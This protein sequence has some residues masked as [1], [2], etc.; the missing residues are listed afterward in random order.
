[1]G[2]AAQNKI[3]DLDSLSVAPSGVLSPEWTSMPQRPKCTTTCGVCSTSTV[4]DG[5]G[6]PV[7]SAYSESGMAKSSP[8]VVGCRPVILKSLRVRNKQ[9]S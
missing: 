2:S 6:I 9:S 3:S 4:R 5:N 7:S 1:M 8:L